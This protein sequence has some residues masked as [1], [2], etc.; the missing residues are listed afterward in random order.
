MIIED[1]ERPPLSADLSV[2]TEWHES[3]NL[4]FRALDE[5]SDQAILDSD[6][7]SGFAFTSI[8]SNIIFDAHPQVR[9]NIQPSHRGLWGGDQLGMTS[10]F[11]GWVFV[12]GLNTEIRF[13]EGDQALKLTAGRQNF[14]L[15]GLP[16]DEF[17]FRDHID[18]IRLDK[19]ITGFGTLTFMPIE[20]PGQASTDD[21]IVFA[22]FVA[23]RGSSPFNFRGDT[24]TRRHGLIITMDDLVEGLDARGYGFYTDIG[25]MGSGADISYDGNLGNFSDNDW[26]A[27][28]GIRAAYEFGPVTP[29][30]SFDASVGVD[31]KELVARDANMNGFALLGG[32]SVDTRNDSDEDTVGVLAVADFF[33][34][35]GP[36]Y[37]NDGL[38]FSHGY[39]GLKA[40]H[41]GG[42]LT[43][44]FMGWHP[45]SYVGSWGLAEDIHMRDRKAGTQVI[46][47]EGTVHF[48]GPLHIQAG[49]WN[50]T[51][52]GFT[53]LNIANVD[54]IDPPFGYSRD[55]FR[56]EERLGKSLGNE[57]NM[58][59]GYSRVMDGNTAEPLHID[60]SLVG[61]VFLPGAFYDIPVSRVAGNHLGGQEIGW[62]ASATSRVWF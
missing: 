19:P 42:W 9:F 51:D 21:D 24:M 49:F 62:A 4:D 52:T 44:R 57:I 53:E 31:R 59:L 33:T 20:V 37:G 1:V 41:I 55:E 2:G 36:A 23:Q 13:A 14:N 11:G 29:F 3:N 35:L 61:A 16:T 45:T 34:A 22:R 30:A 6:D 60:F 58:R 27:N 18:G 12:R 32:V 38:M 40:Q 56:A 39:V 10:A 46:H 17:I 7:R 8:D 25:A 48:P 5:S 54:T 28:T 26:V 50:M 15:G 47:A 43:S